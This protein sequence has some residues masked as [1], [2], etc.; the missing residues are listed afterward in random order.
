L[1]VAEALG[2]ESGKYIV[3]QVLRPFDISEINQVAI[4]TGEK[5][6][7]PETVTFKNLQGYP[8]TKGDRDQIIITNWIK[9]VT[10]GSLIL[11]N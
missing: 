2:G 11:R 6:N 1:C 10:P 5:V 4:P 8:I 9:K 7:I 3:F